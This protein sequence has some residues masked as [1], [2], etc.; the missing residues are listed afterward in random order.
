MTVKIYCCEEMYFREFIRTRQSKL[1]PE[2]I[3]YFLRLRC[4]QISRVIII[5]FKIPFLK[6]IS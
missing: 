4:Q 1:K 6:I 5:N 3:K 2:L